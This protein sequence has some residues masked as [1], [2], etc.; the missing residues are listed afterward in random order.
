MLV[1]GA[2]VVDC[3]V[4]AGTVVVWR[5]FFGP[6]VVVSETDVVVSATEVVVV[7]SGSDVVVV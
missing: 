5:D 4:A 2:T 6:V 1:P 3:S 7:L